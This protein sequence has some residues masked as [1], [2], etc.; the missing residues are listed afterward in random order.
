MVG[1]EVEVGYLP[2]HV[3]RDSAGLP[4]KLPFVIQMLHKITYKDLV[5][6]TTSTKSFEYHQPHYFYD[7]ANV[8]T[9]EYAGFHEVIVEDDSAI[10]KTYFH[11][12]ELASDNSQSSSQGEFEDHISKKGMAYRHEWY[13]KANQLQK[14]QIIKWGKR[15]LGNGRFLITRDRITKLDWDENA[16]HR[17]SAEE[18][19][20]DLYGNVVEEIEWGEV[21]ADT[22]TG[23][24]IDTGSDRRT[25]RIG[26]A[27]NAAVN[28]VSLAQSQELLDQTGSRLHE[29]RFYYDNLGLGS[30]TK[31]NLTKQETWQTGISYIDIERTYNSLGLVI[32][33]KDPRDNTI[34]Y[35]YDAF[36]LY[37][38]AITNA[39]GHVAMYE[40]D[41]AT[42]KVTK[43]TDSNNRVY[44]TTYDG[45]GRITEERVPDPSSSGT[46][47]AKK[48]STYR[49]TSIPRSIQQIHYIDSTNA[50]NTF[51]YYDGFDRKIQER[52]E[53]EEKNIF[54]VKDF[55][56]NSLG[57]IEKESLPYFDAGGGWTSRKADEYL[58]TTFS[59]DALKRAKTVQNSV[60]VTT[61]T[62]DQWKTVTI[63]AEDH[64]KGLIKDAHDQLAQ[65]EEYEGGDIYTT[66]YAYN[67]LGN[68][69]RMADS[70]GNV[71]NFSYDGLGRRIRAEDLHAPADTIFGVW[72]YIYDPAGNLSQ[73]VNPKGQKVKY[74][75]DELNRLLSE[76]F[77]SAA[78]IER[79][80]VYDMGTDGIGRLALV[81]A[82]GV[83]TMYEY[84]GRGEIIAEK[85]TVNNIEYVT[86]NQYDRQ[87][88][89]TSI[90][91]PDGAQARYEYNAGGLLEKVAK[92]EKEA[93][94]VYTLKGMA[95]EDVNGDGIWNSGTE[96]GL[97]SWE[98]SL[99]YP[100]GKQLAEVTNT[101]GYFEFIY[102]I[103]PGTYLLCEQVKLGWTQVFPKTANKCHSVSVKNADAAR[104][105]G[106]QKSGTEQQ[107][108][109]IKGRVYEDKNQDGEK[110]EG[111][112]DLN[113]QILELKDGNG[114][115]LKATATDAN[116]LYEFVG[117][118][119]GSYRVCVE[120]REGWKRTQP[121]T[122]SGCHE[123]S[124]LQ[125]SESRNFGLYNATVDGFIEVIRDIDYS[126]TD[127]MVSVV[128][129]NGVTTEYEYDNAKLYRLSRLRTQNSSVDL[130]N[131]SYE[132]DKVGN[133]MRMRDSS[134]TNAA[135][136]A[137]YAYDELYRL[138]SAI[139]SNAAQG[140]NYTETYSYDRIG[141]LKEK[142]G[143]GMYRYEGNISTSYANPHAATAV[144]GVEYAYDANGN[145]LS[146]GQQTYFW[147]YQNRLTRIAKN[148]ITHNY[149][150]D[151]EGN[152]IVAS[153]GNS[154]TIYPNKLYNV[155]GSKI[156]KHIFAN[157][158]AVAAVE[159]NGYKVSTHYLHNDH[160]DGSSVVSDAK[161]AIEQLL[162]YYPFGSIRLD[163]KSSAFDEQRKFTGHEYDTETNLHYAGQRYYDQDV[164]RFV[165]ENAVAL[166]P[167]RKEFQGAL[168]SP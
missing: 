152:R 76:D 108:Y 50:V 156:T 163:E 86:S 159:K 35:T 11:Q 161:G 67:G 38:A 96:P 109:S 61:N 157:G 103:V 138:Q 107:S 13:D 158:S 91:Y 72:T 1:A 39:K 40:Y 77:M 31:G 140:N 70:A 93:G 160:L 90:L 6:N 9:R 59:Y 82:P 58:Y 120:A 100:D 79:T 54:K 165:S 81:T 73:S 49:D 3:Y 122:S 133:I 34:T 43:T 167:P 132:Y 136:N 97:P 118:F 41:Y 125:T 149:Q 85:R 134:R 94:R 60:G 52:K 168:Q 24:F 131:I 69:V 127:K 141:N 151:H 116:G 83:K 63:D 87:G 75:Y 147:N 33:E 21:I 66:T 137:D 46:L 64:I 145:L 12:S 74:T 111:D 143:T 105:F 153:E 101:D 57:L 65:V 142:S 121:K 150:Y 88:N 139:V 155:E 48:T 117:L 84:N 92:K 102:D 113:Y 112:A 14:S 51:I 80:N 36:N 129:G 148:G 68:V 154:Q 44:E 128:F 32:Q 110:N 53:T 55:V 115:I 23:T 164:G 124:I 56:Y 47:V 104:N 28:I 2:S 26:Y 4:N 98:V 20:Y 130:Q 10:T 146:D 135:K 144:G 25:T 106:N 30:V 15:D 166:N 119:S 126:P 29:N 78:G 8:F 5:F 17:D 114:K 95:F 123:L 19:A 18:F 22:N 162:D 16:T 62:Y 7:S 42:G 27:L 37:P 89:T 45:F 71:R 99:K